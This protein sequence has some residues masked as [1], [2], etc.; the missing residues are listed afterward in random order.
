MESP[1]AERAAAEA[2]VSRTTAM[3][4]RSFGVAV[5]V[6]VDLLDQ[7]IQRMLRRLLSGLLLQGLDFVRHASGFKYA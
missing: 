1:E 3:I 7:R 4:I 6:T 5:D 2:E